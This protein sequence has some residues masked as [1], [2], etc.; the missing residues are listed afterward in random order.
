MQKHKSSGHLRNWDPF[1]LSCIRTGL[2]AQQ[3]YQPLILN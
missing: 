3:K 1:C 2:K